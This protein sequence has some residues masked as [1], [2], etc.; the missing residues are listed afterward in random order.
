[1]FQQIQTR[2]WELLESSSLFTSLVPPANRLKH[3]SAEPLP[4]DALSIESAPA[5][6][7]EPAACRRDPA[8]ASTFNHISTY[9][10]VLTAPDTRSAPLQQLRFAVAAALEL[11]G[12]SLGLS[13]VDAWLLRPVPDPPRVPG[14]RRIAMDLEV[15]LRPT[16]TET[17]AWLGT[18]IGPVPTRLRL[19]AA[20]IAVGD[21]LIDFRD[22]IV[23]GRRRPEFRVTAAA[24]DAL[25][26]QR[27]LRAW[28]RFPTRS[29]LLT[30]E[31]RDAD[32]RVRI[33]WPD[34]RIEELDHPLPELGSAGAT[35]TLT[36]I[37]SSDAA[38]LFPAT[39]SALRASHT[40][41]LAPLR[42]LT[43]TL[44]LTLNSL[45]HIASSLRLGISTTSEA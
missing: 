32:D 28:L 7:I 22:R 43:T 39:A 15:R 42:S 13:F 16:R 21:E 17:A 23:A 41:P 18:W 19:V 11:A 24:S 26:L 31:L 14:A 20:G 1:M 12:P 40:L 36:L 29:D 38:P 34:S 33:A 5:L 10:L 37:A 9:R 6:S 27:R 3:T 44:P 8:D 2:V 30:L 35:R 25:A 45:A 4:S